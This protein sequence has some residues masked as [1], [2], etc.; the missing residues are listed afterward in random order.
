MEELKYIALD[1][2]E[3]IDLRSNNLMLINNIV[4]ERVDDF[5]G[6]VGVCQRQFSTIKEIIEFHNIC[7]H[8]KKENENK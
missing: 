2:N 4:F 6:I 1:N 3:I 8:N 5:W 7:L